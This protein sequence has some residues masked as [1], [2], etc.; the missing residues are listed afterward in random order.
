MP[1]AKKQAE[2]EKHPRESIIALLETALAG[3]KEVFG[4]KKFK[5]RIKKASKLFVKKE[6][7]EAAKK[8][9][10]NNPIPVKKNTAKK[11]AAKKAT[12]KKATPAKKA[13]AKKAPAKK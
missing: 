3:L 12:N 2:P 7:K 13:T 6:K 9:K 1:T 10:V 4:E 8:P 11:P 5:S